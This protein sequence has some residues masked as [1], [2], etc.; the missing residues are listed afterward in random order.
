M[1][2]WSYRT[3]FRPIFF[4]MPPARARD[5]AFGVV[6]T[7]GRSPIGP[8]AIDFLGHMRPAKRLARR[9]GG[10]DCP[11]ALGLGAGVDPEGLMVAAFARFGFGFLEV[12]PLTVEARAGSG[13]IE[14]R[15]SEGTI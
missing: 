13:A 1:P 10:I 3:V 8:A 15:A 11:T 9:V 5:L 6:G 14:L 2:D 4:R 7:L 12:G